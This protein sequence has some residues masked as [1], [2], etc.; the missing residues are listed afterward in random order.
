MKLSLAQKLVAAFLGLTLLVLIATLG[1]AR[2]SFDKGFLD[3]VNALEQ[4]RLQRLGSELAEYYVS[5]DNSWDSLSAAAF[6]RLL[7]QTARGQ[8]AGDFRRQGLP[9]PPRPHTERPA[10]A[11]GAPQRTFQPGRPLPPDLPAGGPPQ[12]KPPTAL[13]DLQDNVVVGVRSHLIDERAIV[14]PVLVDGVSVGELRSAPRRRLETPQE[15]SFSRQQLNTSWIIGISF[16]AMAFALSLFLAKGLLAPIK[17]MISHVGHL[18]SGHYS[19]RLN[20]NRSDELGQ[21]TR[22]LDRLGATLEE[23]QNSRRRLLAD[24]SHELRTPL[25]VL[26][27]EIEAMQDG[28]RPL[29]AAQLASL[30]QE[31]K[32]LRVLVDDLYELSISELGGLR[33]QF[34]SVALYDCVEAAAATVQARAKEQGL[35]L[36]F[37]CNESLSVRG[38][39]TR[40]HQLFCNL[41][42]N[43]L[44]YTDAPG[45]IAVSCSCIANQAVVTIDDSPPGVD[46][47]DCNKLFDPLF[48]Q[49]SSRSRRSGG[50]GLGLAICRNI[51]DAHEGVISAKP[52]PL[53]GV[54]L[55]VRLPL[56]ERNAP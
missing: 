13:Y 24:V 32:R 9:P 51:V 45:N 27:G 31:V 56:A 54:R 48:R 3:Y 33:Y 15:T 21:L 16:T 10:E 2:W 12:E 17:R 52:S 41:L 7:N 43:A 1:L 26:T 40:L 25:S 37:G 53:G 35:D 42:E 23:N 14:V 44:A 36:T 30:E 28:L 5:A 19:Q 38:D 34:S 22:N 29:D 55:E 39:T 49:E 18:S 47:D 20:E 8:P 46:A 50:A 6:Q 11:S 4:L